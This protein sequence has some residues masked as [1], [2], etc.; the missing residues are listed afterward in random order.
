MKIEKLGI[1]NFGPFLGE[2]AFAFSR[3]GLVLVCGKNH[4]DPRCD[5]NGSGK[6][7]LFDALDW[8]LF[9]KVPRGD[10]V[11]SVVHDQAT[12]CQVRVELADDFG[13]PVVIERRRGKETNLR[14]WVGGSEVSAL[15]V[16]ETQAQI[17]QVLGVDRATFHAAVYFGQTDL[18]RYADS[19][20]GERMQTLTRILQFEEIDSFLETTKVLIGG[21]KDSEGQRTARLG[22]QQGEMDGLKARD[23]SASMREWE[24]RRVA[25]LTVQTAD[26]R[27]REAECGRKEH[28]LRESMPLAKAEMERWRNEI[29]VPLTPVQMLPEFRNHLTEAQKSHE[30][31][32]YRLQHA[33]EALSRHKPLGE[34]CNQCGQ[35]VPESLRQAAR[36][37]LEQDVLAMQ[38][39]YKNTTALVQTAQAIFTAEEHKIALAGAEAAQRQMHVLRQFETAQTQYTLLVGQ[40]TALGHE[41][42][43]LEQVGKAI[44]QWATVQN[45]FADQAVQVAQRI[46]ELEQEMAGERVEL[47]S[48]AQRRRFMEFWKEGF[49]PSGLKSYILDARLVELTEAA[50]RWVRLLTG[51]VFWVQ[52]Q[53]QRQTRGK[54]I[55]NA[56]EV[57]VARWNPDGTIT[58]R[59]YR[60]LSGGEKQRISFPID[61]GLSHLLASRARQRYDLLLL[62]EVFKHLDRTGKGAMVEMLELLAKEKG[63]VYVIEHD[64]EMQGL[65]EQKVWVEKRNRCSTIHEEIAD[66]QHAEKAKQAPPTVEYR[67]PVGAVGE[68]GAFVRRPVQRTPVPR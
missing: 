11:D 35:P 39:T 28:Q 46:Q 59:N 40:W 9:G 25:Q 47:A 19:T 10:H 23:F 1:Y 2:H 45:P 54:K 15:D 12:S 63:A 58:E 41:Q 31:A 17:E 55:V 32:R 16:K 62:D 52:F 7:S 3:K 38:E 4:D 49:G 34:V 57:R 30:V 65:F 67:A 50:N 51:G 20:D 64:A 21:L 36:Q 13:R 37:A 61:F 6:S 8:A 53:S 24:E 27:S 56:P 33:Q 5:S 22:Y 68:P 14:C 29:G 60:S 44:Q 26:Y 42:R 43:D 48:I 18:V 66:V